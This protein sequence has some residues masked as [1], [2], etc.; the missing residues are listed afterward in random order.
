MD[1]VLGLGAVL[2][3]VSLVRSWRSFLDDD[4]TLADRHVA[5]QVAV[6]LV[7]PVVVLLHELAHAAATVAVGGH[8]TSF[9]Y[10]LFEG[11]VGFEGAVT[12]AQ[13]WF[14][15]LAGNL[16][17]IGI[18]LALLVAGGLC[19]GVR[20]SVRYLLLVG[21]LFEVAFALVGYP[22]LSESARFGDWLLIYDFGATPALSWLT[23]VCH[24]VLV[25]GLWRWWRTG[26]R[27]TL[28]AVTNAE[29]DRL[30]DLSAAV[31]AAPADIGPRLALAN[32]FAGH[33]DLGLAAAAL[34]EGTAAS[35]DPA[36]LHL[37][38]ARL[39]IFRRQWNAAVL[40]SRQGLAAAGETGAAAT[41][42]GLPDRLWANQGVALAQMDRPALALAAF[43]RVGRTMAAEPQIRYSR[44]VA[45]MASGDVVGGRDDLVAVLDAL[46]PGD[47]LRPWAEARLRGETPENLGDAERP[48]W[49]RRNQ[50][51]AAPIS[52]V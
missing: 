50:S 32:L 3:L 33:G 25:A 2:A 13:V 49:A 5:L 30:A 40:A 34:D 37:A 28:F 27:R 29:E 44:A 46:P 35:A 39:A 16:V 11:A 48:P 52:A 14:V 26:L 7:P 8:V 42:P 22:L 36:R 43:D 6:F 20:R 23:L 51:P 12:D 41:D 31:R 24:A 15:A 17:S 45:R 10:G 18:G 47:P 38:R 9:H 1:V 21:G 19:T 4:F